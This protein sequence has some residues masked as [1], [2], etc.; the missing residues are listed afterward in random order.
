MRKSPSNS[1]T[2]FP[3]GTIRGSWVVTKTSTGV[4]RWTPYVSV[5]M[6]GFKAL[7]LDYLTKNIEK[8]ITLYQREAEEMWPTSVKDE[9][10]YSYTFKPTGNARKGNNKKVYENWLIT[11]EPPIQPRQFFRVEGEMLIFGKPS[12][13]YLTVDSVGG[14]LVTANFLSTE[15]FIRV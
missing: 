8:T 5:T 4:Q 10:M 3:V 12:L 11:R 15:T 2:S 6:N 9:G 13:G 7:T 14:K 1:A